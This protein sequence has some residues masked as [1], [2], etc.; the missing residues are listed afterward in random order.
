MGEDAA[1]EELAELLL[2][3]LRQAGAV[4]P[5]S[6]FAERGLQVRADDGVEDTALR[7]AL[8]VDSARDGHGPQVGSQRGP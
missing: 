6:C 5:M 3:E 2:H 4:G 7:L 8:A 1:G